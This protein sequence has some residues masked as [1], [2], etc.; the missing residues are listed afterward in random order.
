[1]TEAPYGSWRSPITADLITSGAVGLASPRLAGERVYWLE[2]RPEEGGRTVVVC[3]TPAGATPTVTPDGHN[4]RS[5]V[6]EY[7]GGAYG[8]HG[9]TLFYSNDGDRRVYRQALALPLTPRAEPLTPAEPALRYADLTPD[10]TRDR[11]LAVREDHRGGGEPEN[12]L[13]AIAAGARG[14]DP[15]RVLAAG[16]DFC[17]SPRPSPDGHRLAWL[18]W[19]H[20]DMPW[21]ATTLWLAEVGIDGGLGAPRAVAGGS[22]E[23]VV[24]PEWGPDGALYFVSDRS[25]WWNLYRLG[26]GG[27][28][29]LAPMS[30]EFGRPQ[31]QFA[32]S[33]HAFGPDRRLY[34]TWTRDGRWHLGV[35]DP[36]GGPLAEIPTPYTELADLSAGAGGVCF[37]A[38]SPARPR[39]VVRLDPTSRALEELARGGSVDADP[40][41]LSQPRAMTFPTADGETAHG[42]FYPPVNPAFQG[43]AEDR[44]PLLVRGHGGPSTATSTALNLGYQFWTSRGIGVLDVNYRGST[45]YGRAYRERLNGAW[46]VA[47]VADCVHGARFLAASG[48]ADPE[49]LAIR[50]SSAGGFT[51]LA[52]LAFHATFRAGAS[53][54]GIGELESL[55]RDTHK[56][57][58]RYLDRLVGPWPA[59]R[60]TYRARSPLHHLEGFTAP[61]I[62]LQGLE[63]RVVPPQ[64]A[65][66]MV[67]ALEARGIP[68][69]YVTFADEQHGFRR[70]ENIRRALEAELYFY[71]RVFG[72]TPADPLDPVPLRNG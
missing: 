67:A 2:S 59:T 45:G 39:A 4:V 13:V 71:G 31:W 61:V 9:E 36:A 5:R 12:T 54:Y 10:P 52:A 64:Q 37:T 46:G 60:D 72:F 22:G 28:Q 24:Q 55:A 48:A 8:I 20:P 69:A 25:G 41:L 26:E 16:H 42:F 40:A 51:A 30:A 47:D 57:E 35:L 68:V 6:H 33:T 49:R 53:L 29:A 43:P 18:T 14:D 15:G 58:A 3:R 38:G 34:C 63:D 32:M 65:E 19:D 23:S 56:F 27:A 62:F 21:D 7:G 44:P 66:A 11:L 1:M 70:G 50:G 17:A